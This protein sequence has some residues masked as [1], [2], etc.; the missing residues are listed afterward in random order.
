MVGIF[1]VDVSC[2][3]SGLR[4]WPLRGCASLVG[5][6]FGAISQNTT[7]QL[8]GLPAV[9]LL[10]GVR[11]TTILCDNT[12][13]GGAVLHDAA[14]MTERDLQGAL[15][16]HTRKIV[17]HPELYSLPGWESVQKALEFLKSETRHDGVIPRVG[18]SRAFG[19]FLTVH[20]RTDRR[21]P[22]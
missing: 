11:P 9:T 22:Q 16:V 13:A 8:R 21:T 20:L 12:V 1:R 19:I 10:G 3:A 4:H 15:L 18:W 7:L 2:M 5:G 14:W 17:A 6:W